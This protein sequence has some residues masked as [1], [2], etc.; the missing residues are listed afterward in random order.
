MGNNQSSWRVIGNH[1]IQGIGAGMI[2]SVLDVD[3][4]DEVLTVSQENMLNV[5]ITYF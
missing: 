5:A 4:L 3:M 2:S 1:L